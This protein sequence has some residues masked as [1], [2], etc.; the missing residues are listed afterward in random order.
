MRRCSDSNISNLSSPGHLLEV[1]NCHEV[2]PRVTWDMTSRPQGF[3]DVDGVWRSLRCQNM[4]FPG[5]SFVECLKNSQIYVFGD[6]NSNRMY[7]YLVGRTFSKPTYP[8][9]WPYKAE[10]VN[11]EWDIKLKFYPHEYPLFLGQK[12]EQIIQYGSV[13][14]LIDGI[15]STGRQ[16]VIVH[17]YLHMSHF[18]MSVGRSRVEAAARAIARLLARNTEARVAFRGPHVS[19][20]ETVYNHSIGGDTLGKQFLEII[21]KAFARLKD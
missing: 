10:A 6:S 21:S 2:S 5:E 20:H 1:P 18:H 13:E 7:G 4:K 12:W 14:K 11:K 15:P 8:G 9:A 19:S 17:Y 16:L 3:W